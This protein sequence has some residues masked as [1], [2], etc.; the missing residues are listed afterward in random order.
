MKEIVRLHIDGGG[1]RDRDRGGMG[2][3]IR[4]HPYHLLDKEIRSV[5]NLFEESNLFG[6]SGY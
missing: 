1:R 3:E 4:L 6:A 5:R 2:E